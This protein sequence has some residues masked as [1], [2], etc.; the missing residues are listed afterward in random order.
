[1][2][3][4]LSAAKRARSSEKRRLR[5][6]RVKGRV[7]DIEK[8]YRQLVAEK[9]LD[10]AR[11]LLPKVNSVLGKAAKTPALHKNKAQRKMSRL[12]RLLKSAEAA[13]ASA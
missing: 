12:T 3:N 11:A 13:S 1:M 4:T 8:Q 9:K 2:A 5:N 10:D 7:K 6:R